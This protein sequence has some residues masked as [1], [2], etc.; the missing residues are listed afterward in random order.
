MSHLGRAFGEQSV[1]SGSYNNPFTWVGRLGYYRQPDTSDYWLRARVYDPQ[2]G[3]FISRDP[4]PEANLY[5]Y[6]GNSPVVLVDPSGRQVG[7]Y[8]IGGDC[9]HQPEW[10]CEIRSP[11]GWPKAL[12]HVLKLIEV[13]G[14]VHCDCR[15]TLWFNRSCWA[16]LRLRVWWDEQLLRDTFKH[17]RGRCIRKKE[18]APV[19]PD[20]GPPGGPGGPQPPEAEPGPGQPPPGGQPGPGQRPPGGPGGGGGPFPGVPDFPPGYEGCE[21]FLAI[22]AG[23]RPDTHL[24]ADIQDCCDALTSGVTPPI[25]PGWPYGIPGAG[26]VPYQK[27]L[28]ELHKAAENR[29]RRGR[30][31]RR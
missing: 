11:W 7:P 13:S 14:E 2:R 6:P 8:F 24:D 28:D 29:R 17:K 20:G 19:S 9:E 1:L 23:Q 4:V 31:R 25:G 5:I 22:M 15:H 30:R 16:I 3:R 27:C 18:P 10:T 26:S 21:R 12:K